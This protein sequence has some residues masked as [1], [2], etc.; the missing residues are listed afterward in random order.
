M[1]AHRYA[2]CLLGLAALALGSCGDGSMEPGMKDQGMCFMNP[3]T[4]VQ[5]I[6]ACT[7]S[8]SVDKP[9]ALAKFRP[10]APLMPLP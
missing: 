3:M 7:D 8:V 5:I 6:N 2:L 9:A 10:D 1:R 4:H